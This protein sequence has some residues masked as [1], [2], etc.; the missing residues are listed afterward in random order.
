MMTSTE[1]FLS[2]MSYRVRM[3]RMALEPCS[4]HEYLTY[5]GE[6]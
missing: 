2:Y 1:W 4:F 5:V 3:G 6:R